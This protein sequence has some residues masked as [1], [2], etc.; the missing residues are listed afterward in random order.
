MTV[1]L[2]LAILLALV[3][4]GFALWSH[5]EARKARSALAVTLKDVQRRAAELDRAAVKALGDGAAVAAEAGRNDLDKAAAEQAKA[6]SDRSAAEQ[7]AAVA[8]LIGAG[9]GTDGDPGA[10]IEL[11]PPV[12]PGDGNNG[13]PGDCINPNGC[14]G[15][16]GDAGGG[17]DGGGDAGGID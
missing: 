7:A 16:S 3:V 9:F 6:D 15:D 17:F 10:S 4:C 13:G 5:A 8:A 14:Y 2:V 12:Q 1:A 11:P